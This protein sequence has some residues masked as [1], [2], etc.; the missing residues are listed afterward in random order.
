MELREGMTLQSHLW[1]EPVNATTNPRLC[2]INNPAEKLIE[3]VEYVRFI[4]PV[5]EWQE[6]GEFEEVQR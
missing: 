2:L 4:V 1:T 3:K 6:K 5:Q